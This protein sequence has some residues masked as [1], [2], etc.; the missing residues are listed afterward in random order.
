MMLEILKVYRFLYFC[1][2]WYKVFGS[3]LLTEFTN[4]M[5]ILVICCTDPISIDIPEPDDES[6]LT[7]TWM[8]PQSVVNQGITEYTIAVTSSCLTGDIVTPPQQFVVSPL[9]ARI[10]RVQNLRKWYVLNIS[11]IY[12]KIIMMINCLCALPRSLHP[13]PNT[14][15][16]HHLP[17]ASRSLQRD[18][19][20]TTGYVKLSYFVWNYCWCDMI[21]C[22]WSDASSNKHS[23]AF[24]WDY[25]NCLLL[26]SYQWTGCRVLW[27]SSLCCSQQDNIWSGI[28]WFKV[29][30]YNIIIYPYGNRH[31][32]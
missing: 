21:C 5:I 19:L 29:H 32:N 17:V 27:D 12:I 10:V 25:W 23:V 8:T 7:I 15:D 22:S 28:V 13:I 3:S 26:C 1:N 4:S 11:S 18:C 20:H 6:M 16:C 24:Q 9:Q 2:L 30:V 31:L 14:D